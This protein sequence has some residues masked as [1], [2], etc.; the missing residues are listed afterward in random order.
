M[1]KR[2]YMVSYRK[3]HKL[4]LTDMAKKLKISKYLLAHL[5]QNDEY[6]THPHIAKRIADAYKLTDEQHNMML[7]L[8]YRPG[9]YYDPDK[10]VIDPDFCPSLPGY[11][12]GQ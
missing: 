6:V 2:N 4:T 8:N 7:P 10:Y 1:T 11:E 12:G 9:K 3:A 5:E